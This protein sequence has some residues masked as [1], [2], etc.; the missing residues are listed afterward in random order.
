MESK[1]II[2]AADILKR[3][4][5]KNQAYFMTLIR[6]AETAETSIKGTLKEQ[7]KKNSE[8]Y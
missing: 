4:S 7:S 5:P 6:V 3:L 8:H 1:V 2:E